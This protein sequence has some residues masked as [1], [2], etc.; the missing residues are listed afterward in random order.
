MNT[1]NLFI[2]SSVMLFFPQGAGTDEES[3]I[4]ILCTRTNKVCY[5]YSWVVN[6]KLRHFF[7]KK[8]KLIIIIIIDGFL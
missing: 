5:G 6:P 1:I 2:K 7:P 3:L 4:D 8:F